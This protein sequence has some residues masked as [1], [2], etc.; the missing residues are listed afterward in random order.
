MENLD[1]R[2]TLGSINEGYLFTFG[3]VKFKVVSQPTG[4]IGSGAIM[5]LCEIFEKSC[6]VYIANHSLVIPVKNEYDEKETA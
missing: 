1:L 3:E 6:F 4:K 2:R 5:V